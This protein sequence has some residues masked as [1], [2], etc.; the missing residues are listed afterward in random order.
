VKSTFD[1][2][3][4]FP[5]FA[6]LAPASSDLALSW[7][8]HAAIHLQG[9]F[10]RRHALW[11]GRVSTRRFGKN[12]PRAGSAPRGSVHRLHA[13][14]CFC[15]KGRGSNLHRGRNPC[16]RR[17]RQSHLFLVNSCFRSTRALNDFTAFAIAP[18]RGLSCSRYAPFERFLQETDQNSP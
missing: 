8:R 5:M 15:P 13:G 9:Y 14:A 3:K 2:M 16:R 1:F 18:C 7:Q 12:G 4:Q 6:T 10:Q 11:S 17:E